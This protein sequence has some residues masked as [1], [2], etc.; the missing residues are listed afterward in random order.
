MILKKEMAFILRFKLGNMKVILDQER[1]VVKVFIN[2][3]MAIHMRVFGKTVKEMVKVN[4]H[5][6]QEKFMKE[7]GRMI[8]C[9]G[10]VSLERKK[11]LWNMEN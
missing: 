7:N 3:K 10:Q 9:T 5:G 2:S 6:T 8:S 4:L 1:G 11:L